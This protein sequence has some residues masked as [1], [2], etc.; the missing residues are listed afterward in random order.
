MQSWTGIG[1]LAKEPEL[2]Q[3][4]EGKSLCKMVIAINESY[5]KE[6]G[7]RPVDYFTLIAWN[8]VA[9][10]CVNYLKKGDKVAVIGTLQNRKY[11]T[12]Q[13]EQKFITEIVVKEIQFLQ[14]KD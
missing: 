1:N 12:A 7:T 2:I 14:K 4:G 10:R 9:E 11:E 13:G 3:V 8:S 5:T 6:D